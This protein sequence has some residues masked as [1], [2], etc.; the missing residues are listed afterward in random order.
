M[1]LADAEQSRFGESPDF[2]FALGDLLLEW[3][4]HDPA[5]GPELVPLIE[6]A[7]QRA[8]AIGERPEL[9]DSVRGRGSFLSAHNLAVLYAGL[10]RHDEACS[11]RERERAMRAPA[12]G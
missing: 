9:P 4:A 11:W 10:N 1:Q 3:A 5:R 6:A 12:S 8:V 7:W 2:C